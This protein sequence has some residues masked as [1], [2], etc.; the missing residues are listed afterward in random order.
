M[1]GLVP[2]CCTLTSLSVLLCA[3]SPCWSQEATAE[4]SP[5]PQAN[6]EPRETHAL[7]QFVSIRSKALP[8]HVRLVERIGITPLIPV[9]TNPTVLVDPQLIK[10]LAAFFGMLASPDLELVRAGVV[11]IYQEND[12]AN[13]IGVYGLSFSDEAAANSRFKELTIDEE[14]RRFFLKGKLLLFVWK[15]DGV[16]DSAFKAIHDY[17]KAAEFKPVPGSEAAPSDETDPW[18]KPPTSPEY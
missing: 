11:A 14:D 15:D 12:P 6:M 17:F 2:G 9:T 5:S 3:C 8:E 10:P 7:L 1:T 18:S 16:S 13:E 4:T